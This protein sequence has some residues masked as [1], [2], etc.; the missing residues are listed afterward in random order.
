[1]SSD[2]PGGADFS[3]PR[4]LQPTSSLF[5]DPA[6]HRPKPML[7]A[8]ACATTFGAAPC[9]AKIYQTSTLDTAPSV[10]FTRPNAASFDA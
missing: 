2:G 1:M 5:S 4:R 3:L 7:Q 8:E 10:S 9:A 6:G